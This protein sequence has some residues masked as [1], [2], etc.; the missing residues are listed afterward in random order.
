[1]MTYSVTNR[2]LNIVILCIT[3][4][5]LTFRVTYSM[6]RTMESEIYRRIQKEVLI[7]QLDKVASTRGKLAELAKKLESAHHMKHAKHRL[8]ELRSGKRLLSFFYLNILI[9]GGV[10]SINQI[11][12]GRKLEELNDTERDIVLR[13]MADPETLRLLYEAEKD[14]LD[15]K[16]LLK[17]HLKKL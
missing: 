16:K 13:L 5:H 10:M 14:G 15:V 6:I 7:P 1:M 3:L 8:S 17:I 9:L 2:K 12:H 11:L 4:C